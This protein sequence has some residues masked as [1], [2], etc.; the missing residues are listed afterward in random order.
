MSDISSAGIT[1][2][3]FE[4]RATAR[5][6]ARMFLAALRSRSCRAP[7]S[8]S[9]GTPSGVSPGSAPR[10]GARTP[11]RSSSWG[12]TCRAP[13][14]PGRPVGT[15]TR[16]GGGTR[17]IRSPRSPGPAAGCGP[18]L[19]RSGPR[20]RSC[21]PSGPGGCWRGAGSPGAR[22]GPCGGRGRPW[23][24]PWPGSPAVAGRGPAPLVTAGLR[25]R[26]LRCVR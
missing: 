24:P 4:P 10:A 5:P 25:S 7:F 26:A 19:P 20:S 16:A 15:C 12:T 23:P 2:V 14:V 3:Y 9:W 21:L 22:C 8:R 17:P 1:R 11:S 13:P 6:A 18:S